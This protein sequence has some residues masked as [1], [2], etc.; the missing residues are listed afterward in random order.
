MRFGRQGAT[1]W[2]KNTAP[3][4]GW[5]SSLTNTQKHTNSG[6][7]GVRCLVIELAF[8][9][10]VLFGFFRLVFGLRFLLARR[11]SQIAQRPSTYATDSEDEGWGDEDNVTGARNNPSFVCNYLMMIETND[12]PRLFTKTGSGHSPW[13]IAMHLDLNMKRSFCAR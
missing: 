3:A 6:V 2:G 13:K 7:S 1:A 9:F 11:R 10:G 5:F 4:A 8:L 12:L